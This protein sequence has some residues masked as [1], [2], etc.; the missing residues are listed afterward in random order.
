MPLRDRG[1]GNEQKKE[2]EHEKEGDAAAPAS[3]ER[4]D[5]GEGHGYRRCEM[6]RVFFLSVVAGILIVGMTIP[7]FSC[8]PIAY[9]LQQV[10]QAYGRVTDASVPSPK[11]LSHK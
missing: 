1:S 6:K 7:L 5:H 10:Y 2:D 9:Y 8:K 11:F 4:E 3:L